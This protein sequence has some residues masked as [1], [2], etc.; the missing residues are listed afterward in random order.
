MANNK[1]MNLSGATRFLNKLKTLFLIRGE[2]TQKDV[3]DALG[4]TPAIQEEVDNKEIESSAEP[5]TQKIGD[6]WI[7][8]Y[9]S[10]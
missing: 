4:Y 6:C 9:E 3:T 2:L 10:F 5:T 8:E 7:K 1:Y